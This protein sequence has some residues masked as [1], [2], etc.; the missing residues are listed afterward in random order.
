MRMGILRDLHLSYPKSN[1]RNEAFMSM[2]SQFA[3]MELIGSLIMFVP[4]DES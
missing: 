2:S 4:G 3:A 1:W